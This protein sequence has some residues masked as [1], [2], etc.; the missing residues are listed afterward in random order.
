MKYFI[1]ERAEYVFRSIGDIFLFFP[2]DSVA[3]RFCYLRIRNYTQS[4]TRSEQS[5]GNVH[6]Q[7][8]QNI[9]FSTTNTLLKDLYQIF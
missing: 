4:F 1:Q 5:S 6:R 2:Q 3:N 7:L 8:K 9:Q